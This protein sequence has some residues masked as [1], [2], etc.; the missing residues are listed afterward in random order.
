[1][2]ISCLWICMCHHHLLSDLQSCLDR[3]N[4]KTTSFTFQGQEQIVSADCPVYLKTFLNISFIGIILR[5]PEEN[6]LWPLGLSVG[7][8][9]S[10]V[11]EYRTGP[12]LGLV[13]GISSTVRFALVTLL[14]LKNWILSMTHCSSGF[15]CYA[16]S[17]LPKLVKMLT[18]VPI[19]W[20]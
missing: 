12:E 4:C 5:W 13:L 11:W 6:L 8:M 10:A 1:M 3:W 19:L 14:D 15:R 20:K 16:E 18:F 17:K 9:V 2:W 7:S